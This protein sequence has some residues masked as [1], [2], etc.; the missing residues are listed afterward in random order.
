MTTHSTESSHRPASENSFS[1]DADLV[2]HQLRERAARHPQRIIFPESQDERVIAAANLFQRQGLGQ[3]MVLQR[4]DSSRGIQELDSAVQVKG[5]DESELR[6]RCIEQLMENRK[7]KGLT[8][9][10][11]AE[12]I[13]DPLLLA[14]LIVRCGMAD[15][16]VAGSMATTGDVIRAAI[17][18][19]GTARGQKLV[20]SYFLMQFPDRAWTYADCGVV[21][22]PTAAELA[23][24]TVAAA[25]NHLLLTR[26]PPKVAL[27]SFSTKGSAEHPRVTKVRQ[28]LKLLR[29]R[30]PD[31][32]V[33]GELQFDAAIV[34]N[35]GQR[36]APGSEVAGAANVFIFPDL[37]S[38]NIA[39]KITE[40]LGGAIALGPLLQGLA[41]P[42]MDLSRGCQATDIVDVAVIASLMA[43]S[44]PDQI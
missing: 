17:H 38:G 18:G 24:I 30:H 29:Q 37:D 11:A 12:A 22:D 14:A 9:A 5:C 13:S 44:R 39:Y 10:Q 16:S 36:K 8:A 28:T 19:V 40:R 35:I 2:L 42:C 6:Q 1:D 21:P 34:P 32:L 43:A 15:A 33:D 41:R 4:T 25:T 7:H 23:E 3:A 31:L 27:L 26:E 20:S